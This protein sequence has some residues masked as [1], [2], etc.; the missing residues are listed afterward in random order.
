MA[1]VQHCEGSDLTIDWGLVKGVDQA[2]K[3]I[4]LLNKGRFPYNWQTGWKKQV[5]QWHWGQCG[6][7][8]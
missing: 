7:I 5:L 8:M 1:E 4:I 2:A 6:Q 3:Q